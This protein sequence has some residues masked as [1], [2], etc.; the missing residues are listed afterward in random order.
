MLFLALLGS[1]ASWTL[2][3]VDVSEGQTYQLPNSDRET[4]SIFG[5][6]DILAHTKWANSSLPPLTGRKAFQYRGNPGQLTFTQSGRLLVFRDQN[7]QCY[8]TVFTSGNAGLDWFYLRGQ[9]TTNTFCLVPVVPVKD[10]T[11]T[12]KYRAYKSSG[13][14][15]ASAAVMSTTGEKSGTSWAGPNTTWQSVT[16]NSLDFCLYLRGYG[17][18]HSYY[19]MNVELGDTG[20]EECGLWK[21]MNVLGNIGEIPMENSECVCNTQFGEYDDRKWSLKSQPALIA[22]IAI[23]ACVVAVAVVLII[24]KMR[25]R[26]TPE[27]QSLAS[28]FIN[29]KLYSAH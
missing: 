28:S 4:V 2:E 19:S 17:H 26:R 13:G 3:W 11:V 14:V 25:H 27:T 10:T 5:F 16:H 23:G 7:I 22:I 21:P 8:Y 6:G 12:L 24:V 20:A 15:I 1:V 18:N 9:S 29:Q